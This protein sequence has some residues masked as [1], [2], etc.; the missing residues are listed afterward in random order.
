MKCKTIFI[1][2]IDT[3]TGKTIATGLVALY[4]K[5]LGYKVITQKIV[6]TSCNKISEDIIKHREIMNEK[7]ND[8]DLQSITCPYIFEFPASPHLSSKLENKEINPN[9]ILKATKELEKHFDYL[10]IE[11]VGGLCV[12]LNKNI[13]L[14][15]YI[16]ANKYPLILIT[17]GKLGSINHTLLSLEAI[18]KRKI[19]LK[20]IIYNNYFSSDEIINSDSKSF[21][22][23][24]IKKDFPDS[25]FI[26]IGNISNWSECKCF[27]NFEI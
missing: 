25:Q 11:G 7:L 17:S 10:L 24:F 21:L 22:K 26:E 4:L 18:K 23:K 27:D 15:D 6:Q 13:I 14:I 16:V 8:F 2:G 20:A 3:N 5:K 12:P 1:S 9:K 19:K